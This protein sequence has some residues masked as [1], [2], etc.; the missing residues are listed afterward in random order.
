MTYIRK[1]K[2]INYLTCTNGS[3]FIVRAFDR[4][5]EKFVIY[6]MAVF[7]KEGN[8]C[9]IIIFIFLYPGYA[10]ITYFSEFLGK[11][12]GSSNYTYVPWYS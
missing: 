12:Q 3:Y 6:S 10:H 4:K 7:L 9:V 11:V 1:K 2:S 5:K 8:G